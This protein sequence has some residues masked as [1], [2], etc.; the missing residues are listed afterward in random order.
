MGIL[1]EDVERV[2]TEANIVEVVG[3]R[4]ALKPQGRRYGGLCPFH[5]ERTPSF[6]VSPENGLWYCFGCHRGGDAIKFVREL[7][8]LDFT[9]AV[10]R[11]AARYHIQLRYD[12][13]AVSKDRQRRDRLVAVNKAA[14]EFYAERLLQAPAARLARDHLRTRGFDGAAARRFSLGY[15]PDDWDQLSH[16]LQQQRFSREDIVTVGL[17]FVNKAN[18]LQDFF[19]HRLMFP[20][21]D[22]RGEPIGFGG[23]DLVGDGPKYRNTSETPLYRKSQV[24]YGLNWS[25]ADIVAKG[26]VIVCEGYTDVMACA[27]AGANRA[28]ATCG[29]ALADEHFTTLKNFARTI[30]VAYDADAAGQAAAERFYRWEQQYE[31]R[32]KVAALP[33]GRDP[34]EVWKDA[35]ASLV[36]AVDKA[37]PFLEFRINRIVAG[38][39]LSDTESCVRA[40]HAVAQALASHP[41]RDVRVQYVSDLWRE[42]T[43]LRFDDPDD[44][45]RLVDRYVSGELRAQPP[46]GPGD[47]D[48]R[49]PAHQR[50]PEQPP[51][52][53]RRPPDRVEVEA[54]RAAVHFPALV[55]HRLE[56]D[57]FADPV[58][59]EILEILMVSTT[60]NDALDSLTDEAAA[61][62]NRIA[63]EEPMIDDRAFGDAGGGGG[64]GEVDDDP[65]D[66]V[67]RKRRA[68]PFADA[69]ARLSRSRQAGP[70]D[71]HAAA[72]YVTQTLG[73]LAEAAS[74]RM[75]RV[76]ERAADERVTPL[77]LALDDY[78]RARSNG[79][80]PAAD[81]AI[82]RLVGLLMALTTA[83][84][85]DGPT[86]VL[87]ETEPGSAPD[88]DAFE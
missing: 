55:A 42:L 85:P 27:L 61:T 83:G 43:R 17:A 15:A 4:V 75:L 21:F 62:L 10:E 66:L 31:V 36:E 26:E 9:E 64:A 88:D 39:D 86:V 80:W 7:D 52:L 2:R 33:A 72:T 47:R 37:R 54:L 11:L 19:R 14:V 73:S 50:G 71:Q 49:S 32:L 57:L 56:P 3:E 74:Q 34:A 84:S 29:T 30:V 35:P 53:R 20:I 45:R 46:T 6:S 59:T 16:H 87:P 25:R 51:R 12:D 13:A 8:G 76:L 44:L 63:V 68:S 48:R 69:R 65:D 67:A 24:L 38:T 23:R 18:K 82:D 5:G 70:D 60:L 58:C 40:Q 78:V 1:D 41:S 28:V 77:K 79:E 22:V 81:E